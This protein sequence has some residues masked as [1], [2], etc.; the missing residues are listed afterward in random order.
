MR[1]DGGAICLKFGPLIEA[2]MRPVDFQTVVVIVTLVLRIK[3]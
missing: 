1:M 3:S 2:D